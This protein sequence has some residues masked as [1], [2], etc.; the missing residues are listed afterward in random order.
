MKKYPYMIESNVF[1]P[2]GY[3]MKFNGITLDAS[4]SQY[5]AK[6]YSYSDIVRL[7]S[8]GKWVY[9]MNGKEYTKQQLF[10]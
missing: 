4:I 3:I 1:T 7:E 9:F 6:Q 2:S 5:D 10:I 8:N